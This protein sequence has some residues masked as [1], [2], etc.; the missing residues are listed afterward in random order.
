MNG[1]TN[2]NTGMCVHYHLKPCDL[3][4]RSSCIIVN[5]AYNFPRKIVHALAEP[6]CQHPMCTSHEVS[7]HCHA[8]TTIMLCTNL[9]VAA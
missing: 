8:S 3:M 6:P 2:T 5:E 1:G 7:D 4:T 9:H